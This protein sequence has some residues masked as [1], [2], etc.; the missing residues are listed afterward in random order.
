MR[1]R[2]SIRISI[3]GFGRLGL[4]SHL[5]LT[6]SHPQRECLRTWREV[7]LG[8]LPAWLFARVKLISNLN[9]VETKHDRLNA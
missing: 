4:D 5:S 6:A 3:P 2:Q 9:R 8:A 1:R 7:S